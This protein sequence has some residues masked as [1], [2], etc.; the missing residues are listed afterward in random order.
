MPLALNFISQGNPALVISAADQ[1]VSAV[2][3]HL[4]PH[5][6][7][8]TMNKFF[9]VFGSNVEESAY[10]VSLTGQNFIGDYDTWVETY[11]KLREQSKGCVMTIDFSFLE[12]KYQSDIESIRRSIVDLSRLLRTSD[13][14]LVIVS[15]PVFKTLEVMKSV[16]DVHL[17]IF[18]YNG[19]T[20]LTA[21]KP[22]LFLSNIQ[23]E[24]SL[25]FPRAMLRDSR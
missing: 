16:S 13:D 4:T 3:R 10:M 14:L 22:Q 18:E 17:K 19:A 24:S 15:R 8:N 9:R 25:G 20:M 12:L 6:D 7:E 21:V 2:T 11:E 1:D 5:I 23:I